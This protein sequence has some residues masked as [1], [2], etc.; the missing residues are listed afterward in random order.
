V[1]YK[2]LIIGVVTGLVSGCQAPGGVP[3]DSSSILKPGPEQASAGVSARASQP[4]NPVEP[5]QELARAGEGAAKQGAVAKPSGLRAEFATR[6]AL[7]QSVG[8][9]QLPQWQTQSFGEALSAFRNGCTVLGKRPFWASTCSEAGKIPINDSA[10][11][12]AFFEREF[13]PYQVLQKDRN[14]VGN[15]TGYFEPLL[16]GN[17]ER[18][19]PY[20]FPV[21]ETPSDLLLLD[22]KVLEAGVALGDKAR[23]I[24]DGREVKLIEAR[25][26]AA[27]VGPR[28]YKVSL[29][30][31]QAGTRDRKF[32]VRLEGAQIVSYP[33]RQDIE[34]NPKP[35]AR[36]IAWVESRE[37][38]YAMQVQGS[39][40]I[41]L[42]NG[43]VIRV[44]YAEQNGHA[45]I[46]RVLASTNLVAQKTR[47]MSITTTD[48]QSGRELVMS[49]GGK[50]V[51]KSTTSSSN[52]GG[53][54]S[55][56]TAGSASGSSAGSSL[57]SAGLDQETI[58]TGFYGSRFESIRDPSYVFFR[59]ITSS[60]EGPLGAMGIHLTPGRS[61][62]VDP[63]VTPLGTPVMI[64]RRKGASGD[65]EPRDGARLMVAQDTGGAIRGPVRADYFWGF[66]K[67]AANQA[68]R[69]NDELKMWILLPK[70]FKPSALVAA[71]GGPKTR[72]L[73]GADAMECLMPDADFC[74]E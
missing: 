71:A 72:T 21:Y 28:V 49:P 36:P 39:G 54:P 64:A 20:L 73:A 61:I 48:T 45:F 11:V 41:L 37:A 23:Y 51:L 35:A 57:G 59:E 42:P 55:V 8:F 63:R 70:A 6:H 19:A 24:V 4:P 14:D 69:T 27:P 33:S 30:D 29:N 5:N 52:K 13:E 15:L 68:L 31:Q 7:F 9:E 26:G 58:G 17:R 1:K 62:A 18:K 2:L 32:R 65:A 60:S 56:L 43:G 67:S 22:A 53:R 34:K 25:D 16:R 38:L 46:P 40:R 74:A 12:R 44:A 3:T 66:G 10:S 50:P 47:G